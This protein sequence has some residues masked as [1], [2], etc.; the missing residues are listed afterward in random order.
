MSIPSLEI[1]SPQRRL[2]LS[3]ATEYCQKAYPHI[4]KHTLRYHAYKKGTLRKLVRDHKVYFEV[5]WLDEWLESGS[6]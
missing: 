2:T 3:E 5:R 6:V 4:T 1:E